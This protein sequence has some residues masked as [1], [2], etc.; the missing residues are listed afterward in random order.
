[1]PSDV[2]PRGR[3]QI[4]AIEVQQ[5]EDVVGEGVSRLMVECLEGRTAL[6]VYRD[7]LSVEKLG[8]VLAKVLSC[9]PNE[10]PRLR[11]DRDR[12]GRRASLR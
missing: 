12:L 9:L 3:R 5:V 2:R 10:R 11:R 1:V 4:A 6:F 7:N 8:E